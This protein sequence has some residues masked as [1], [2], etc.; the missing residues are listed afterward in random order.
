MRLSAYHSLKLCVH[1]M[2]QSCS[3][4][5]CPFIKANRTNRGPLIPHRDIVRQW[6]AT[7]PALLRWK[8][9][10]HGSLRRSHTPAKARMRSS[11]AH[12]ATAQSCPLWAKTRWVMPCLSSMKKPQHWKG[13]FQGR[14]ASSGHGQIVKHGS[15]P[16]RL[17][18]RWVPQVWKE[19][20][21]WGGNAS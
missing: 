11:E 10:S 4:W 1:Q 20:L 8:K 6:V 19:R 18:L 9:R 14:I 7:E 5:E 15:L 16:L 12:E 13:H 21:K 17:E 2:T 3:M